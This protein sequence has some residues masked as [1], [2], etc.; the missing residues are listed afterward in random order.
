MGD[1]AP[2]R[3]ALEQLWRDRVNDVKL[4]LDFARSYAKEVREDVHRGAVPSPDGSFAYQRALRMETLALAEY[5]RVMRIFSALVLE[6][7]IPD[8]TA[9]QQSKAAGAGAE[10]DSE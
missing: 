8:E 4:R 6:G 5:V 3:E 10:G 2:N 1:A 9:W 7:K